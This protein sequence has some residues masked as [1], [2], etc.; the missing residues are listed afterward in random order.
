MYRLN[1]RWE[2][3]GKLAYKDGELRV[4]R[5]SGRFE[6]FG[7]ALAVLRGRYHLTH[8]WDGLAE[9]RWLRDRDGDNRREGALLGVYRHIGG[10]L[11]LGVGYNFTDFSDDIKDAE[12]DNH[13]WFVDLIGKF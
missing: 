1:H 9:Y 10:N 8:K 5:D 6:D 12:Y 3:G 13:G 11:K 2:L 7:V 4:T